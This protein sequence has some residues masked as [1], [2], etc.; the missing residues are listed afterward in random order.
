MTHMY[1]A[2]VKSVSRFEKRESENMRKREEGENERKKE[3]G[4]KGKDKRIGEKQ[5]NNRNIS[6]I[7]NI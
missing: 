2:N 7:H 3:G 4:E 6:D 1:C 5:E